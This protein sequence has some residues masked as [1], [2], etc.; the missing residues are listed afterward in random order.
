MFIIQAKCQDIA[1]T[2]KIVNEILSLLKAG[3]TS[4]PEHRTTLYQMAVDFGHGEEISPIALEA[5]APLVAKEGNEAALTA[6]CSA[7]VHHLAWALANNSNIAYATPLIKELGSSKVATRRAV[8]GAIGQAI[9]ESHI[10]RSDYSPES[11][12]FLNQVMSAFETA[13]GSASTNQP[14]NSSGF[15][16]GYVAVALALGP[17]YDSPIASK[18]LRSPVMVDILAVSPK[19]SFVLTDKVYPRLPAPEDEKWLLRCLEGIVSRHSKKLSDEPTR[20]AVGLALIHLAFYARRETRGRAVRAIGELVR[21][22]PALMSRIIRDTLTAWLQTQDTRPKAKSGEDEEVVKSKSRDIGT[23]LS[24]VFSQRDDNDKSKAIQEDIA[25]DFIVLAHH[26]EIGEDAQVS[27]ITMVQ[28]MGLDPATVAIDKRVEILARLW[29]AASAPPTDARL[30]EAA[31][32]AITTLA[33]VQPEIYVP[34]VM[35]RLKVDL[36]PA[37]LDFIGLEERGIWATPSDQLF[38]DGKSTHASL[39]YRV[40]SC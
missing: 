10:S 19:P 22:D 7:W 33:F 21:S 11:E 39:T 2:V 30:A 35:E 23:L 20:Q 32:R 15:L 6:L 3:K 5:L 29:E 28:S 8:S 40:G 37:S 36:D 25:V 12:A 38:V 13:L 16:E 9:W 1:V 27:W 14:A 17:L 18:L 26:P 24:L 31:Y 34:A 4:S